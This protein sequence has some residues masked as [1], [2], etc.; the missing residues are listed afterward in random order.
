[1][2]RK[3]PDDMTIEE[4]REVYKTIRSVQIAAHNAITED[5]CKDYS[6]ISF[7]LME[8]A[9]LLS[10]STRS[11]ELTRLEH[12]DRIIS[13]VTDMHDDAWDDTGVL[14]LKIQEGRHDG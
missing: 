3:N 11:G 9:L 14:F 8:L 4:K 13:A 1:M 5:I 7:A 10:V 6:L 2:S 12:R